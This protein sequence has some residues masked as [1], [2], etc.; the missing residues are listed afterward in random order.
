MCIRDSFVPDP[1]HACT[2]Y[3]CKIN[4]NNY[5]SRG[6]LITSTERVFGKGV[7]GR[8][9]SRRRTKQ[10]PSVGHQQNLCF[11]KKFKKPARSF[12]P[13]PFAFAFA[14]CLCLFAVVFCIVFHFI[15]TLLGPGS[16]CQMFW[17][18]SSLDKLRRRLT[19]AKA[20]G[21][22]ASRGPSP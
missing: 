15:T 12:L 16:R 10:R 2:S 20:K 14:F 19:H 17:V 8:K 18:D 22:C 13:L 3:T 4:N 5:R 9:H 1:G 21:G 6:M 7:L 11:W